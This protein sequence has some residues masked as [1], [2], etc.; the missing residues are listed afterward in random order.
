LP[1]ADKAIRKLRKTDPDRLPLL[2]GVLADV[3]VNGWIL[4]VHSAAKSSRPA[5]A[6]R[7]IRD[8][9]SGG[10]RLFFFWHDEPSPRTLYII[11]WKRSR[12]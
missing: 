6:D 10:Y 3:L 11:A 1:G 9:G 8:L 4:S 2:D 5:A 12:S 7:E